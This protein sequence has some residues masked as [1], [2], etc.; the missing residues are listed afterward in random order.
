[1]V[2]ALSAAVLVARTSATALVRCS[3]MTVKVL[4]AAS[5]AFLGPGIGAV[6]TVVVVVVVVLGVL[7]D[8]VD[9][10]NF[11]EVVTTSGSAGGCGVAAFTNGGKHNIVTTAMEVAVLIMAGFCCGCKD[12]FVVVAAMSSSLSS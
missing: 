12:L 5:N 8:D 4:C 11:L 6:T 3:R 1:M 7:L 9:V 2:M 10:V